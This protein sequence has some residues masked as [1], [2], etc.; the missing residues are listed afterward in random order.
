MLTNI[1]NTSTVEQFWL[2]LHL[3]FRLFIKSVCRKV[4]GI[5]FETIEC[6]MRSFTEFYLWCK[7]CATNNIIIITLVVK[8]IVVAVVSNF[9]IV[10]TI[11]NQQRVL[12]E[13]FKTSHNH[14]CHHEQRSILFQLI[15]DQKRFNL[16]LLF[17]QFAPTWTYCNTR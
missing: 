8:V 15:F 9:N 10:Q 4:H 13:L 2:E 1:P 12:L 5:F 7:F 11:S 17:E 16:S 3:L 14:P 6:R